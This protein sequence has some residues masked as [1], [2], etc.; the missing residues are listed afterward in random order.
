VNSVQDVVRTRPLS[1]LTKVVEG[2]LTSDSQIQ[3]SWAPVSDP[4]TGLD[5]VTAY[6]V[7]WDN[8]NSGANWVLL[9]QETT[10]FTFVYLQKI[11]ITRSNSY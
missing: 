3:I 7:Y 9:V 8:G 2:A 11:G 10:P 4:V 6:Q 1:P 5:T